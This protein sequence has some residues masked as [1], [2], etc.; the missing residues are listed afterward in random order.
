MYQVN[1]ILFSEIQLAASLKKN[2][3]SFFFFNLERSENVVWGLC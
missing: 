2:L 1:E 3:I